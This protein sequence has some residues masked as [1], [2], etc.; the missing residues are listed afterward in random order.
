MLGA[1]GITKHSFNWELY[2]S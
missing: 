2:W 1:V